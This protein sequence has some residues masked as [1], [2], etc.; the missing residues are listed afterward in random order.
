MKEGK[1]KGILDSGFEVR[2][3]RRALGLLT[4]EYG[5]EVVGEVFVDLETQAFCNPHS[6]SSTEG[7]EDSHCAS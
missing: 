7:V 3:K 2:D 6:G 5:R 4:H 1:A